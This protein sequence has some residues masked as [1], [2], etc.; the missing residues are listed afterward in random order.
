MKQVVRNSPRKCKNTHFSFDDS[1][2]GESPT[3]WIDCVP[4]SSRSSYICSSRSRRACFPS[5]KKTSAATVDTHTP[6]NMNVECMFCGGLAAGEARRAPCTAKDKN[7]KGKR[8]NI[9]ANERRGHYVKG[10]K[11]E[12]DLIQR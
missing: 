6:L 3:I 1:G 2:E 11:G 9:S 10:G 4:F 5:R 7:R 8:R 12:A